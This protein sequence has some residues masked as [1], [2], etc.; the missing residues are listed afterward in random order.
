MDDGPQS[1][2]AT[3]DG[4]AG[5][6]DTLA[7]DATP[8]DAAVRDRLAPGTIV[9]GNFRIVRTLGSGA[10]GVVYE[11]VDTLLER[12]VAVKLRRVE[13]AHED[14]ARLWREAKA[15]A[16]LSHPNVVTVYEVGL[17]EGA[18]CIAI[19]RKSVV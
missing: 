4:D 13:R 10:M 11:A 12:S 7:G 9:A 16:R 19:D 18:L 5:L 3:S 17:H 6:L 2:R 15:M 8:R 14:A 1:L